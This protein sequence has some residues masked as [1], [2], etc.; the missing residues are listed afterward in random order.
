MNGFGEF[1]LGI[2][3]AVEKVCVKPLLGNVDVL[4]DVWS[5]RHV[6][7][8]CDPMDYSPLS[9]GFFRQEYWSG[10]PFP[11]LDHLS[12]PETEPTAP[13]TSPAEPPGKPLLRK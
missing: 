10:L 4:F 7:L 2:L 6:Q 5:L 11:P 13:A 12:D 8:F 9:M 1:W 3:I